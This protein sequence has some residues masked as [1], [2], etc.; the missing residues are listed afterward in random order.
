MPQRLFSS[1]AFA[2]LPV[3]HAVTL[4]KATGGG[5]WRFDNLIG[6]LAEVS[7]EVPSGAVS[8]V[9]EIMAEA[10]SQNEAI[11]WVAGAE[12]IFFPPDLAERGL[13]LSAI[14]VIR[15]GGET[16]SLTATEWL[17]RSGAMGLVVV[18][19]NGNWSVSDASLGRIQKIAERNHCA[20]VFLTR[21]RRQDPS[22]G[23]R[24]ALRGCIRRSDAGPFAIDIH[25]IKDKRA[26]SSSRQSR[27]YHGPTGMY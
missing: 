25:A 1:L 27:R 23:S 9:A 4:K 16:D 24:I 12:T 5:S 2:D 13:D 18:D 3:F 21:K 19:A 6:I 20:I 14:A 8:F 11:A 22:L 10:Q 17:A 26:N 7:E 15:A